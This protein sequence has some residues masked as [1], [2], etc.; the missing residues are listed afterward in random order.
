M[1]FHRPLMR[2]MGFPIDKGLFAPKPAAAPV[3][4]K[5]VEEVTAATKPV[6]E[7]PVALKV[8]TPDDI[9]DGPAQSYGLTK[10]DE[11]TGEIDPQWTPEP[12]ELFDPP[13]LE[14]PIAPGVR[15]K[16]SVFPE[17]LTPKP[18]SNPGLMPARVGGSVAR[19]MRGPTAPTE[20][21]T[22]RPPFPT[23]PPIPTAAP[24][25]QRPPLP[26]RPPIPTAF[27]TPKA[28]PSRQPGFAKARSTTPATPPVTDFPPD[29][30][31]RD[32]AVARSMPAAKNKTPLPRPWE[33]PPPLNLARRAGEFHKTDDEIFAIRTAERERIVAD[34]KS[35]YEMAEAWRLR[36][37]GKKLGPDD[38]PF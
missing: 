15:P 34:L 14:R 25:T 5:V 32:R 10:Y 29:V 19:T 30:D 35:E 21:A 28:T 38:I 13:P 8:L 17:D 26:K 12:D 22:V 18:V 23:R 20:T 11:D 4:A 1:T 7:Q 16:P 24:A 6:V 2:P 37:A 36:P 33:N 31:A 27:V 9:V 3:T